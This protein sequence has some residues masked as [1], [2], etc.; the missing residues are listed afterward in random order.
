[1]YCNPASRNAYND[2]ALHLVIVNGHVDILQFL[3]SDQ[4]CDPKISGCYHLHIVKY[5]ID[6]QGC[7][8]SCFDENKYTSL[9]RVA[10]KGHC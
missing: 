5:L 8:P 10:M 1:M 6:E 7:N 4:N 9:H 3:I 2:T